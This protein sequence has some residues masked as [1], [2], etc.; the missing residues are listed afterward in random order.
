MPACQ[1]QALQ[2]LPATPGEPQHSSGLGLPGKQAGV[3]LPA[4]VKAPM[5][6]CPWVM[7]LIPIY[8]HLP[9]MPFHD[10]PPPAEGHLDK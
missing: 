1:A 3:F 9:T 10:L 5:V 6:G 4:A 8:Q 7:F 2:T